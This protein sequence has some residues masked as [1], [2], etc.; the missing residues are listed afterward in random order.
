VIVIEPQHGH[1]P[2]GSTVL[3]GRDSRT[4]FFISYTGADREWAE[5]VAWQLEGSGYTTVLQAWDFR[6]GVNFVLA[7]QNATAQS[8]RTI[9]IFSPDYLQARYTQ[10]EWAAAF[11]QDPTGE[12]GLLVPIRVRSGGATGLLPPI[13]YIDLVGLDEEAARHVLRAGVAQT[14]AKPLAPPAFPGAPLHPHRRPQ[15]PG[16]TEEAAEGESIAARQG[17]EERAARGMAAPDAPEPPRQARDIPLSRAQGGE[18]E[19][20][21]VGTSVGASPAPR[22]TSSSRSTLGE[23]E[24]DVLPVR[25]PAGRER[26]SRWAGVALPFVLAFVLTLG[27]ALLA[28]MLVRWVPLFFFGRSIPLVGGRV[29]A[30]VAAA[31]AWWLTY[32]LVGT[33]NGGPLFAPFVPFLMIFGGSGL[34]E[35]VRG[36]V[37]ALPLNIALGWAGAQALAARMSPAGAETH[38]RLLYLFFALWTLGAIWTLLAH[39][40]PWRAWWM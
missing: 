11:A 28:D 14:R 27:G 3:D 33:T 12:K 40:K 18:D 34:R 25:S 5:W 22:R 7:M 6:P 26:G 9:A 17:E 36:L 32:L 23:L 35:R 21:L 8:E 31:L 29:A 30:M 20:T 39:A 10:A 1:I 19:T 16:S 15:F 13:V 37:S 38:D 4:D 24:R 2:T